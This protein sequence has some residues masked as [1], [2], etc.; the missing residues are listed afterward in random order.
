MRAFPIRTIRAMRAF[1]CFASAQKHVEWETD[2]RGGS[3]VGREFECQSA[4]LFAV[5]A[6][7]IVGHHVYFVVMTLVFVDTCGHAQ[8]CVHLS[9]SLVCRRRPDG[10]LTLAA[11]PEWGAT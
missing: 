3:R 6:Y 8:E 5:C 9:V 1:S 2:P 11:A 10:M 7:A 4:L